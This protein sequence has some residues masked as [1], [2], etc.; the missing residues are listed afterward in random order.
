MDVALGSGRMKVFL[1]LG[2][3]RLLFALIWTCS[4]EQP[5][6]VRCRPSWFLARVKS[7][8]FGN[9]LPVAPDEVFLGDQCP[10]TS[11]YPGFYEFQYHPTDCNIRIE[12]L[13][14]DRL[15]FISQITFKSKFS[16]LEAS[17][18]VAC[19]VPR[20][21][22]PKK[23]ITGNDT[24]QQSGPPKRSGIANLY[25]GETNNQKVRAPVGQCPEECRPRLSTQ[26]VI[27]M[28]KRGC[29]DYWSNTTTK[30]K[31]RLKSFQGSLNGSR[32]ESGVC[33]FLGQCL[34]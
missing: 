9:D 18:P 28:S 1:A 22:A 21:P 7:T 24:N 4:G 34:E 10:V 23:I 2:G 15:L 6:Y 19:A 26:V 14:E 3:L 17:I 13:P 32:P 27:A 11:V 16:D 31:I 30:S 12:V 33:L 25:V 20:H 29:F 8:A 5:V